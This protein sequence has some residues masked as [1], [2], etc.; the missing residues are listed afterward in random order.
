MRSA[1]R[2]DDPSARTA[3]FA[4]IPAIDL[5]GGRVVRLREGDF[6]RETAYDDDPVRV[7]R[8]WTAAGPS[9]LHVVDLDGALRG[10]PAQLDVVGRIA[11]AANAAGVPCQVAGGLRDAAAVERAFAAGAARV[12]LGTVLI[13]AP[14]A[15][16]DLVRRFGPDR[17]CAAIDV[18]D[19]RA[20]GRGWAAAG[21]GGPDALA[22]VD[23]LRTVGLRTFVV[24]A[25][26]RDG[27][28]GGPDLDLLARVIGMAG[29]AEVIAS[30]GVSS[31]S[32]IRAVRRLGCA[33]AILG[34]ALYDGRLSLEDAIAAA[35]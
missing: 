34:R 9:W 33:G 6:A 7:A 25:I 2:G 16:G 24:T 8:R 19:G 22:V 31:A 30:G 35:R 11:G 5:R 27:L 28:L 15:A 23:S 3:P 4:V 12:I 1:S 32:D 18:R 10:T 26:A 29:G 14:S 17:I 20:V 21:P 13:D